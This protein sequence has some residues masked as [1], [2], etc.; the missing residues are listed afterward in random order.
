[1]RWGMQK[2]CYIRLLLRIARYVWRIRGI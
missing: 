1:M 2:G